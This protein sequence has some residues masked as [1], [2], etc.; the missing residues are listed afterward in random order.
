MRACQEADEDEAHWSGP[1]GELLEAVARGEV[2]PRIRVMR[3]VSPFNPVALFTPPS[4]LALAA[5]AA[6]QIEVGEPIALSRRPRH[7]GRGR[8]GQHVH[9]RARRRRAAAARTRRQP[10][11]RIDA[12]TSGNESRFINDCWTPAGCAADAQLLPRADLRRTDPR[13]PPALREPTHP[14]RPRDR[15]LRP[16]LLGGDA[17]RCCGHTPRE[18]G[19]EMRRARAQ[20]LRSRR[21]HRVRGR[22]DA[23]PQ[24]GGER[25]RVSASAPTP[26]SGLSTPPRMAPPGAEPRAAAVA[27]VRAAATAAATASAPSTT[28][29]AGSI[30]RRNSR[31]GAELPEVDGAR[32]RDGGEREAPRLASRARA[33]PSA[34][35]PQQR[36]VRGQVPRIN[37]SAAS[38]RPRC[39][40]RPAAACAASIKRA[41]VGPDHDHAPT[42]VT[43]NCTTSMRSAAASAAP[44]ITGAPS[45]ASPPAAR[46]AISF[47]RCSLML[48][49]RICAACVH[50]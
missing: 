44:T 45:G 40:A 20:F 2:E 39:S 11:L 22:N 9:V 31:I 14:R 5:V 17:R 21:A 33:A 37:I 24:K 27:L 15:R 46:R 23:R 7:R 42:K 36:E 29:R 12:S 41:Y 26:A 35:P 49:R 34:A 47:A 30:D 48:P 8:P 19:V 6:Y 16:R 18:R 10:Q 4:E 13:V 38:G 43:Q 50:R 25:A 3:A 1:D 32:R 28:A